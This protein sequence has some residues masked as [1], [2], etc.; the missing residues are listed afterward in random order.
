MNI[1][2]ISM[3]LSRPGTGFRKRSQQINHSDTFSTGFPRRIEVELTEASKEPRISRDKRVSFMR[4]NVEDPNKSDFLE[5]FPGVQ[6]SLYQFRYAAIRSLRDMGKQIQDLHEVLLDGLKAFERSYQLRFGKY[7]SVFV[8]SNCWTQD[9]PRPKKEDILN[10]E[11]AMRLI[12]DI[13]VTEVQSLLTHTRVINMDDSL[14]SAG[15]ADDYKWT[16]LDSMMEIDD[17]AKVT[18]HEGGHQELQADYASD[19]DLVRS[20]RK[21]DLSYRKSDEVYAPYPHLLL[22]EAYAGLVELGFDIKCFF[23][24]ITGKREIKHIL[25]G[26]KRSLDLLSSPKAR[27]TLTPEGKTLFNKMKVS[28]GKISKLVKQL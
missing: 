21:L 8:I 24:G 11:Y 22:H 26:T 3:V 20:D 14:D 18:V 13:D 4:S 12:G 28:F 16:D 7:G 6:K 2:E 1:K 9:L 17:I 27:G 15:M 5:S 19:S 23:S 25:E 10:F